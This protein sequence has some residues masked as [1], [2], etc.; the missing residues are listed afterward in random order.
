MDHNDDT[1]PKPQ[2]YFYTTAR[3]IP[4]LQLWYVLSVGPSS[5]SK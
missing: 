2:N 5:C 4:L 3:Q 1:P